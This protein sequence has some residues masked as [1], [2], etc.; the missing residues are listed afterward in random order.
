MRH[1]S[2][3]TTLKR[4][5]AT[6]RQWLQEGNTVADAARR[7]S[8][9]HIRAAAGV[10]VG[11]NL[12]HIVVFL[13]VMTPTDPV[14]TRWAQGVAYTHGAMAVFMLVAGGLAHHGLRGHLTPRPIRWLPEAVALGV[15]VWAVALTVIDQAVTTNISAYLNACAGVAI[16]L[17][18]RPL[19]AF[20]LFLV[21]W[22]LLAWGLGQAPST[23]ASLL[24]NQVNAATAS[25]LALTVSVLLWRKFTQTELL[26]RALTDSNRTLRQQQLALEALATRD[27]LTALLNRREFLR[28]AEQELARAQRDQTPLS[29]LM[30][31]LDHFKAINDAF[32]HPAGDAVLQHVA[33]LMTQSIRQT[34]R[35]ARFGGEEFV[36][37]LPNTDAVSARV[38]A[39]KLRRCL[40][41]TP[42]PGAPHGPGQPT[43][44]TTSVGLV[45]LPAGQTLPLNLLLARADQ[46]LYLAKTLGRNRVEVA[47][48]SA[49]MIL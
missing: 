45:C 30:I 21:A 49:Q 34:D 8:L 47:E 24:T 4:L 5:R 48:T 2:P 3:Q 17:L 14:H 6:L 42:A 46:A 33:N 44:V 22:S 38:L 13:W 11:L 32:G 15:L 9:S 26:Q 29:L 43:P 39:D 40:A 25:V 18:L 35:V 1:T 23:P 37:L 27:P 20:A 7:L 36:V 16:V 19:H 41:D 10:M 31:D 12:A 28:L